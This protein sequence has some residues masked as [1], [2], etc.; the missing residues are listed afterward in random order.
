MIREAAGEENFMN[1]L[2]ALRYLET[3]PTLT[4]GTATKVFIPYEAAGILGALG[5]LREML[6]NGDIPRAIK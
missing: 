4:Q 5:G 6:E 2:V 3:L 1:Y